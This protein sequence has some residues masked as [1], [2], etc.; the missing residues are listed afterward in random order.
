MPPV[1]VVAA[2]LAV[3][4]VGDGIAEGV[5]EVGD[6]D[7]GFVGDFVGQVDV[8]LRKIQQPIANLIR[9]RCGITVQNDRLRPC[10]VLPQR[11]SDG[12]E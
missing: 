5:E 11:S 4:A 2:N 8:E 3:V 6:D 9:A 12:R 10:D 1:F 7:G